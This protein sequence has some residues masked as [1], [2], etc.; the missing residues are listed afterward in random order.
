M[1]QAASARAVIRMPRPFSGPYWRPRACG[2]MH[3]AAP[4]CRDSAG[5]G[6]RRSNTTG[7]IKGHSMRRP[8]SSRMIPTYQHKVYVFRRERFA[9]VDQE[10]EQQFAQTHGNQAEQQSPHKANSTAHHRRIPTR[11]AT[12]SGLGCEHGFRSCPSCASPALWRGGDQRRTI[13]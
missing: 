8:A 5:P 10:W 13:A 1:P 2:L 12:F 9:L 11:L 3:T 7:A 4:I 6:P